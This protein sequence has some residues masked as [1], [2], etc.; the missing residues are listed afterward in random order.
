MRKKERIMTVTVRI[1]PSPTGF[2]HI[3]TART[4]LFNYYFAKRH[5][6]KFLL[7]IED[8]DQARSTPGAV[9]ALIKGMEWLGMKW[10]GEPVFQMAR[11]ARHAEVAHELVKKGAAYYCYMTAEEIEAE[12]AKAESAGTMW[13]YDRR[14]RDSSA[15]PP[16]GIKPAIRIKAPVTEGALTLNDVAQG[17][18]TIDHKQLDDFILLRSDG[19]PTYMLAV[20]V[21]D[22]D[23]GITHVV[24]GDDH[25]NNMF[26][27]YQIYQGMGWAFPIHAHVPLIHG[28][29]GKKLS[30]R[31]NAVSI[32]EFRDMGYL[33]EALRN[34]LLRL[35]WSHGDDE[36][37]SDAQ[38]TEWFDLEHI[39]QSPSCLDFDKLNAV[40]HHYLKL[41]D[42][43]E[44]IEL[45]Q[46]FLEKEFGTISADKLDRIAKGLNG[47]KDRS[48][49]LVE[50]AKNAAIYLHD[51]KVTMDDT[52]KEKLAQ[53][54]AKDVL[55]AALSLTTDDG[56]A[57]IQGVLDKTGFK[58]GQV[59]PVLRAA[60]TG[61]MQSPELAEVITA[62][63]PEEVQKR[64]KAA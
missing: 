2:M 47:L 37:F 61:T 12:R 45:V 46:P 22:H 62:L 29:D 53:P 9:E 13:H 21:D 11:S 19:T 1:A 54:H 63:G 43:K 6:G 38:A 17:D 40:N 36:I 16:E 23:M 33:P 52:A 39:G 31:R 34:Y 51:G 58:M 57:F 41:R 15:T 56:K 20:V 26:R 7:R 32:E 18:V 35:G 3:G 44:L 50:L 5:N 4:G 28:T 60:L 25:L 24:R 49:T 27:Q 55:A 64:L 10:D 14:W 42:N 8:T 30:K 48:K 59:G